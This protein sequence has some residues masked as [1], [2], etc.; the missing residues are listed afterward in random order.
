M[1][2]LTDSQKTYKRQWNTTIPDTK[3]KLDLQDNKSLV[4]SNLGDTQNG[5]LGLILAAP[6]YAALVGTDML[7][8][9][10]LFI[11][12]TFPGKYQQ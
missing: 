10:Q 2:S 8:A 9:L 1:Q 5:Y 3:Q 6:A 7:G 4:P 11:A 12:P